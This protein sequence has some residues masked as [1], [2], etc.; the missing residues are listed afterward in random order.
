[1]LRV[2]M[3]TGCASASRSFRDL[4]P[5][6]TQQLCAPRV[7][8]RRRLTQYS[9]PGR[10]V[11][12][13]DRTCNGGSR[14]LTGAFLHPLASLSAFLEQHF[15]DRCVDHGPSSAWL[16]ISKSCFRAFL[17]QKTRSLTTCDKRRVTILLLYQN[18]ALTRK[19]CC[20]S[21]KFSIYHHITI[22]Q[23]PQLRAV[24]RA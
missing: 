17:V 5:H 18:T 7:R 4:L 20:T 12:D 8:R 22:T 9:L 10:L 14:Q 2:L 11:G 19:L 24:N 16:R 15:P 23:T 6:P 1:M 13:L 3:E 21:V